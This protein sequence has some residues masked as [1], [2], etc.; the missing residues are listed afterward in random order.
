MGLADIRAIREV[1]FDAA[2]DRLEHAE[3]RLS[4][5]SEEARS[6]KS[7]T[8]ASPRTRIRI[9]TRAHLKYA[10]SHQAL[11]VPF[12]PA[13]ACGQLRDRAPRAVR[14]RLPRPRRSSSTCWRS[15]PSAQR[16]GGAPAPPKR[17]D[18]GPRRPCRYPLRRRDAIGTRSTRAT[19]LPQG[20]RIDGPA[21]V[22]EATG[23]TMI[24]P[25]WSG[26]IDAL[27]NLSSNVSWTRRAKPRWGPMPTR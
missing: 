16:A 7:R 23:T 9:E 12:G 8:R 20:A 15:R 1:Q 14:L 18:D 6:P 19:T 13:D 21:I 25:G 10:G 22:S 26:R 2:L 24:E 4:E 3:Q 11:A 27:G 17:G 5:L